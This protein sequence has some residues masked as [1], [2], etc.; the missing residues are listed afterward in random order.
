M[1]RQLASRKVTG[2]TLIELMI[3]IAIIGVI[4]AIAVPMYT[5]YIDT[6]KRGAMQANIKNI[7]FMMDSYRNDEGSYPRASGSYLQ[8]GDALTEIG[9]TKS[10][11]DQVTYTVAVT[12]SSYA[13]TATHADGTVLP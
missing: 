9:W 2:V 6:A 4:A 5:D 10:P 12:A 1:S 13:V 3:T 7:E 11:T 8:N